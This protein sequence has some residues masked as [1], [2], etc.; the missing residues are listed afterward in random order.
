MYL[1]LKVQKRM[2]RQVWR[3]RLPELSSKLLSAPRRLAGS[4]WLPLGNMCRW[5]ESPHS[6][7]DA[8]DV[9]RVML[10]RCQAVTLAYIGVALRWLSADLA[11]QY[12]LSLPCHQPHLAGQINDILLL[13]IKDSRNSSGYL[14][15]IINSLSL[16]C[17]SSVTA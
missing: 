9:H 16:Q 10:P 11:I 8:R 17:S 12:Q 6:R 13:D 7:D 3:K 2:L 4:R 14:G 5:P 15:C 1:L